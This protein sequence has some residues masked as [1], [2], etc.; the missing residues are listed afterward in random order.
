MIDA[1]GSI[2]KTIFGTLESVDLQLLNQN[3]DKLF[4]EGNELKT[5]VANQTA[6]TVKIISI[7][8]AL[9]DLHFQ[10]DEIFNL[11]LLGKRGIISPQIINH[12][13]FLEQY[14]K[15]LG[16]RIMNKGFSPEENN[17]QNSLDVSTLT[18]FVQSEKIFFKISIPTIIDSEWD[19]KQVY[20][21]PTQKNGAFFAPLVEHP[22]FFLR[23]NLY[24]Y[25][26]DVLGQAMS[27]QTR[28]VHLQTNSTHT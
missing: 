18:L 21:M 23:I 12:H 24:E 25:R 20:P 9:S 27:N 8:S 5:T 10:L 16:N 7:E 13:T 28:I 19:I 14:A 15:A 1:I 4:S 22:I 17:F 6:L 2:S 3:I 26:P 11:I